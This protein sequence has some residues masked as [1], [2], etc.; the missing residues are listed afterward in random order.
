M[1][2]PAVA[3]EAEKE[4]AGSF[5]VGVSDC[6]AAAAGLEVAAAGALTLAA[7]ADDEKRK[8]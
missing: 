7:A 8:G 1:S 5:G 6:A 4:A 3:G 2:T